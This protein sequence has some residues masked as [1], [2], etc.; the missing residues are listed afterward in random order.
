MNL[1][2]PLPACTP[3]QWNVDAG[4]RP[5]GHV[6]TAW[7]AF[8]PALLVGTRFCMPNRLRATWDPNTRQRNRAE[9]H[10]VF[11]LE[12][13]DLSFSVARALQA[14][15]GK[16]LNQ[17]NR[18]GRDAREVNPTTMYIH[19]TLEEQQRRGRRAGQEQP[20]GKGRGNRD[21]RGRGRGRGKGR[22]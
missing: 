4:N 3:E 18:G 1:P 19:R 13:R 6:L 11:K 8:V 2:F 21:G 22:Q 12:F 16:H 14:G 20:K 15:L 10:F 17:I 7:W 9:G 5:E